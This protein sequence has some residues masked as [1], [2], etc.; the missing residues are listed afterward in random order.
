M[1]GCEF[2]PTS[3]LRREPPPA[4]EAPVLCSEEA[5]AA[6]FIHSNSVKRAKSESAETMESPYSI[7]RAA[8]TASGMR[9]ALR[10][11]SRISR[12]RISRCLGPGCG[13]QEFWVSSHDSTMPHASA[14][15]IGSAIARGL[16]AIRRKLVSDCH[17]KAT[18][19][20]PFNAA[21]SQSFERA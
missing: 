15:L 13:T 3:A 8:S 5:Q 1:V 10:C 6:G 19:L 17:G 21:S 12:P 11:R 7:Q 14:G 18:R 20:E 16:V 9:L 4:P 2:H